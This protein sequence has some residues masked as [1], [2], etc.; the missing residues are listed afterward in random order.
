MNRRDY[1]WSISGSMSY[2]LSRESSDDPNYESFSGT[3][4]TK[5][6]LV[7]VGGYLAGK[8]ARDVVAGKAR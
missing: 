1:S 7:S 8:F 2:G 5:H 6:G 4:A 3:V